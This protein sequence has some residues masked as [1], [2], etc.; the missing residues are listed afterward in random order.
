M[1]KGSYLSVDGYCIPKKNATQDQINTIKK[2]LTMVPMNGDYNPTDTNI[3]KYKVYS[4]EDDVMRIPRY[5]GI[6]KFGLP[7]KTMF[8]PE[9]VS[10]EFTGSLREYQIHIVDTCMKH[11]KKYGGGLLVVPCGAGKTTMAINMASQLGLKTLIVTHKTFLQDQWIA[12]CKQFT[13]S[14]IG[15]IRQNKVEVENKDFVIAMIQSLSKRDYDPEIFKD[16][17]LVIADECFSGDELVATTDGYMKI[18][19]LYKLYKYDEKLPLIKSYN[20]QKRTFEFKK[21]IHA[22][23]KQSDDIVEVCLNNTEKILCTSNHKFL[24]YSGYVFAKDLDRK[25]KKIVQE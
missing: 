21:M 3:T 25:T 13:K 9:E 16:F 14:D 2:E 12:R 1:I 6:D 20:E 7:K 19:Q 18:S 17:G 15:I 8:E 23:E 24:T 4:I 11:I 5:Y 10:I 22:W